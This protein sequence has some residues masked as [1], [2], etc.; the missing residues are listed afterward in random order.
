MPFYKEVLLET[1]SKLP[2]NAWRRG[3]VA[4]F[5]FLIF[6]KGLKKVGLEASHM[7]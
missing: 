6:L 4:N 1:F 2:S 3:P 5:E 7:F